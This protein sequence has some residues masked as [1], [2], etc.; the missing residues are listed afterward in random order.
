MAAMP[1]V[2]LDQPLA[3][4][5][6]LGMSDAPAG[7]QQNVPP[8]QA[9][10]SEGRTQ[11][12]SMQDIQQQKHVCHSLCAALENAVS[13]LHDLYDEVFVGHSEAIARLSV[14]IA[15]KVLVGKIQDGDYEIESIIQEAL[16]N[17]PDKTRLV[18]RLNPQDLDAFQQL[19]DNGQTDLSGLDLQ[20]DPAIGRAECVVESSKGTIQLLIDEHLERI[21]KALTKAG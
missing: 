13:R 2:Q 19:Q 15:R 8:G 7:A 21:S 18:V 1:V 16:K 3:G 14:E 10:Q 12:A 5:C 17:A 6:V 4:V 9:A 20:A 11:A